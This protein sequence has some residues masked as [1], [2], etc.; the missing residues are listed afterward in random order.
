M[1]SENGSSPEGAKESTVAVR[2]TTQQLASAA[3]QVRHI[4]VDLHQHVTSAVK[5]AVSI[6][7]YLL[8]I[9]SIH[10]QERRRT[11][12]ADSVSGSE[13]NEADADF[14]T[15]LEKEFC[16]GNAE[17]DTD[18]E[19]RRHVDSRLRAF[20]R[21]MNAARYFGLNG[22]H[23]LEDVERLETSGAFASLTLTE[24]YK[25]K[26][27]PDATPEQRPKPSVHATVSASLSQLCSEMLTLKDDCPPELYDANH[28]LLQ[29]TLEAYTGSEWIMAGTSNHGAHGQ[30]HVSRKAAVDAST[31]KPAKKASRK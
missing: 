30:V 13:Q 18:E 27:L 17:C 6:G 19:H 20:R 23:T 25:P 4:E 14:Y 24:I 12:L 26:E 29:A 8:K 31:A 3:D 28:T 7:V 22:D 11:D 9:R 10:C 21:Y 2:D 15:Y 1:P 5:C 16:R